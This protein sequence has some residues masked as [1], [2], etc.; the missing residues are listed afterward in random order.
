MDAAEEMKALADRLTR[1]YEQ[2]DPDAIAACYAPD[3]R[4]WHNIDGAEQTVEDQLAATRWLNEQLKNL[5][6]EIV[7]RH[8]FD[9]GYVQQYVV[10]GTL[11]NG[12]EAFRMPL[13]MNVTVRDGRIARLE[14]Y[15]D[16]AHLIP[17][18]TA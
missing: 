6:H 12:G 16:S 2:N 7:S 3:A 5:R 14:E 4:I 15:L 9:G 11:V 8:F 18:Q 1:A 17:L 10:H 13:C